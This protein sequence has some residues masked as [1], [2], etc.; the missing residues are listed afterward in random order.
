ML[1]SIKCAITDLESSTL[2]K[3]SESYHHR[4]TTFPQ[5]DGLKGLANQQKT[6]SNFSFQTSQLKML[7]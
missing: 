7:N 2:Y 5:V 1:Q 3:F 6:T 4:I